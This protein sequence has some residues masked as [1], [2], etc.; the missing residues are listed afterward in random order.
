MRVFLR[1]ELAAVV[2]AAEIR[3]ETPMMMAA[4]AAAVAP[5]A[6]AAAA[7]AAAVK[8]LMAV[9]P[10]APAEPLVSTPAAVVEWPA[11]TSPVLT[12]GMLEARAPAQLAVQRVQHSIKL[13]KAAAMP[14][15]P[16]SVL[17]VLAAA[18]V[19]ASMGLQI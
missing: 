15:V 7:V 14:V 3:M 11:I 18:A 10:E 13:A 19:A 9:E 16:A 17:L 1:R 8:C 6:T 5:T 2:A 12:A 4:V